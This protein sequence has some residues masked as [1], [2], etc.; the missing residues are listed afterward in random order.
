MQWQLLT[1]L[2]RNWTR[3][4]SPTWS[5]KK[6][7]R[8]S[9]HSI[10]EA[11][12]QRFWLKCQKMAFHLRRVQ[13]RHDC[14]VM[15]T[16]GALSSKCTRSSLMHWKLSEM[17]LER[18][19]KSQSPL[20][21]FHLIWDTMRSQRPTTTV[22]LR[23]SSRLH[24]KPYWWPLRK[25]LTFTA[26]PPQSWITWERRAEVRIG[27]AASAEHRKRPTWGAIRRQKWF[28]NSTET[29]LNTML[30]LQNSIPDNSARI[31]IRV[32]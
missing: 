14:L 5:L 18:E 19:S 15:S 22:F 13:H 10:K 8:G 21:N 4:N 24:A 3:W 17:H 25:S 26:H 12:R 16:T 7:T 1:N 11:N 9:M 27:S 28:S 32:K 29:V 23:S 6:R 30:R 2:R 31:I 20:Y